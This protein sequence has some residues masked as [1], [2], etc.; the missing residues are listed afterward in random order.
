MW[1]AEAYAS[2]VSRANHMKARDRAEVA[3]VMAVHTIDDSVKEAKP[4][5]KAN[6]IVQTA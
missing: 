5:L 6:N 4:S 2:T 3:Q 1:I